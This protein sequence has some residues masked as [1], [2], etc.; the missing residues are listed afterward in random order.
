MDPAYRRP[1]AG[2]AAGAGA[3]AGAPSAN[4]RKKPESALAAG[5]MADSSLSS[6]PA[7]HADRART[8]MANNAVRRYRI[9]RIIV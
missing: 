6:P 1:G 7:P 4:P 8:V 9:C 3:G 5:A 2:A